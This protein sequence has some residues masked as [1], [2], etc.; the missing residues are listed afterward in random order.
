MQSVLTVIIHAALVFTR[1]P[2]TTLVG[3]RVTGA[4]EQLVQSLVYE[5]SLH[6]CESSLPYL[7]HMCDA[8]WLV[9]V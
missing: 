3:G 1:V 7:K 2:H 8:G 6:I 5:V 4:C 9:S